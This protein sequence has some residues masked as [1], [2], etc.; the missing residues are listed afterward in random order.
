MHV[1]SLGGEHIQTH[2]KVFGESDNAREKAQW[3][4]ALKQLT[5]YGLFEAKGYKGELFQ[6]TSY[7]YEVADT[8]RVQ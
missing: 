8:L 7:G 6:V 5:E 1:S 4:N 2:G 3:N